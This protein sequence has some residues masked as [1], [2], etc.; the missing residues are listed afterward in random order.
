MRTLFA[1]T[2]KLLHLKKQQK[3]VFERVICSRDTVALWDYNLHT[4][5]RT[6]LGNR[7]HWLKL[8]QKLP[9]HEEFQREKKMQFFSLKLATTK[10][11]FCF[12][13]FF[14]CSFEEQTKWK[15]S[16]TFVEWETWKYFTFNRNL[17][18]WRKWGFN[19]SAKFHFAHFKCI[20]FC[21]LVKM[22]SKNN[23]LS[24]FY[25]MSVRRSSK[26]FSYR[27]VIYSMFTKLHEN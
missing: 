12:P 21:F 26:M 8:N 14:F 17:S 27:K 20:F 1:G 25:R 16:Q 19:N 15:P 4:I 9:K 5:S 24:P 2:W 7:E 3:K 11:C 18:S 6:L 10:N 22:V 23:S 13:L